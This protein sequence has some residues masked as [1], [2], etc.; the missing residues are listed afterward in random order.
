M[1][2]ASLGATWFVAD[3]GNTANNCNSPGT[4]C[5]YLSDLAG[6]SLVANDVI[7]LSGTIQSSPTGN[8][9]QLDLTSSPWNLALTFQSPQ[10]P[11]PPAT[12]LIR[13]FFMSGAAGSAARVFNGLVFLGATDTA[14]RISG[15]VWRF[16][17]VGFRTFSG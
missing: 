6:K 16:K 9:D 13:S 11:N 5:R 17:Y 10:Q 3:N 4:A 15:G 7:V 14:F 2:F 12:V 8:S 1:F